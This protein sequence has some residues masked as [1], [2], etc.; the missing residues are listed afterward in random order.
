[1]NDLHA[2]A[3]VCENLSTQIE[4]YQS[5]LSSIE[6]LVEKGS[7][8]TSILENINLEEVDEIVEATLHFQKRIQVCKQLLSLIEK[9]QRL[10]QV[11]DIV[12]PEDTSL[13]QELVKQIKVA[14]SLYD[15]QQQLNV[16]EQVIVQ[17]QDVEGIEL[18][19]EDIK[20]TQD[21]VGI[22]SNLYSLLTSLQT[23]IQSQQEQITTSKIELEEV[24]GKKIVFEK[25]LGVC[26]TCGKA[27]N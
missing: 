15:I 8:A 23:K 5:I 1:M 27:F 19:Q 2:D 25:E 22:Y 26:P 21:T 17:T 24:E 12:I 13:V 9:Q 4:S 6:T 3:I 7:K 11:I 16:S 20:Q 10:Q 18:R 14:K